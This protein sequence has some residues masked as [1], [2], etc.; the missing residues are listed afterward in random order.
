LIA[1]AL[2]A[3]ACNPTWKEVQ[4]ADGKVVVSVP[5]V[6]EKFRVTV[7][8]PFGTTTAECVFSFWNGGLLTGF[9]SLAAT[10]SA[11]E[12]EAVEVGNRASVAETINATICFESFT[13]SAESA[14]EKYPIR[15]K[16][17]TGVE[18]VFGSRDEGMAMRRRVCLIDSWAIVLE[19]RGL[20]ENVFGRHA[21]RFFE[22]PR[23]LDST[24]P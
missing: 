6:E 21:E 18:L 24:A 9:S 22:S 4:L 11:V 1:A 20:S 2:S 14:G 7:D 13:P 5:E 19:V 3:I 17:C 15:T 23:R 8:A 16:A 12:L 10:V